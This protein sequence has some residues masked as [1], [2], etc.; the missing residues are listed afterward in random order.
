M[1]KEVLDRM[2]CPEMR[3]V[4]LKPKPALHVNLVDGH[5]RRPGVRPVVAD[6]GL[7]VLALEGVHGP[8]DAREIVT[9][10]V[11]QHPGDEG[12]GDRGR[13]L[14]QFDSQGVEVSAVG[15]CSHKDILAA[16]PYVSKPVRVGGQAAG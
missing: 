3:L 8:T 10:L 9:V 1:I 13:E 12:L 2:P 6:S 16:R 5:V 4:H 11:L 15:P 7:S 14:V